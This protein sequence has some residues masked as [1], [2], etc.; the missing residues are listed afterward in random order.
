MNGSNPPKWADRFL[1]WY[2]NPKYL[3]EIEGDIYELF[4]MRLEEKGKAAANR[5]FIWD[6]FRFFRWSNIKRS[7]SEYQKMNQFGLFQNYL[8]LGMRNINR[9]LVTSSINIFGLAV[10]IGMAITVFIYTDIQFNMNRFHTK[11]DR[12]YQI[13]NYVEQEGE[14]NLWSD[15]PVLLGPKIASD[16]SS[17]EATARLEYANAIIRFEEEAFDEW[18]AFTDPAYLEIFD[19]P[20][21]YGNNQALYQKDQI[22]ISHDMAIKYFG[23]EDPLGKE[24]SMDFSNGTKKRFKVSAVMDKFL[25]NDNL[26]HHFH[27]PID[28][29]FDL[30]IQNHY[31]WSYFTDVTFVLLKE[32]QD[33]EALQKSYKEWTT[34][35]H[36]S[37]PEWKIQGFEAIQ[38]NE[39]ALRTYNIEGAIGWDLH[40]SGR[41]SFIIMACLLLGMACFNFMNIAVTGAAKRLKEIGLRKVM[42]GA[43][44][45]IIDQFLVEN[46]LQCFLGLIVGTL[47][48]YFLFV[49]GFDSIIPIDLQFRVFSPLDMISFF[50]LL[51]FSVGLLSATY[52]AFY[53]SRFDPV[54]IFK[55]NLK[56]GTG[57]KFS[58]V[59][60]GFQL[61]LAFLTV[62]SSIVLTDQL[63]HFTTRDW[64]Y[65][66]SETL[67]VN[68]AGNQQYEKLRNSMLDHPNV[69]N[70]GGSTAHIGHSLPIKSI[71]Y[72]DRKI[73]ARAFGATED[74]FDVLTLRLKTGRFLTDLT[75][76]QKTNVVI[77]QKFVDQVGWDDPINK[78]FIMDSV[79]RIVVGI[80][81]D[82]HYDQFFSP[83]DPVI[84][85]GI[86]ERTINYLSVKTRPEELSTVG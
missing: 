36:G 45:Q 81:E 15:T 32:G 38:L 6:V 10:A 61:F 82:F 80:V 34:L 49:P 44:R 25:Y 27:I 1:R 56:F 39:L 58:K 67:F 20:I 3:E 71:D 37:N 64:G 74:Y 29:F 65:N 28:N 42:G 11:K 23:L 2:C 26:R 85:H 17:V 73:A 31:N 72:H 46:V 8:K 75:I 55:G 41:L 21:L 19:F 35:Q 69:E 16:L 57:N 86:G 70:I 84:I 13:F 40:P 79:R 47:L 48:A 53:I 24:L 78:T 12:I 54:T 50:I 43:K 30:K 22:V 66:P 18:I 63:Y 52:P 62:V 83:I 9:N 60:L 14:N 5:R 7:N 33:I 4:D 68:V 76:D 51:L 59:L 77:N